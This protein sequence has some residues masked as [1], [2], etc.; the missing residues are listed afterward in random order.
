[1]Q[2]AYIF[3]FGPA[4]VTLTQKLDKIAGEPIAYHLF[5]RRDLE[6]KI[7]K[8]AIGQLR[9]ARLI[10]NVATQARRE[11]DQNEQKKLQ[12]ALEREKAAQEGALRLQ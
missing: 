3:K 12:K 9:L 7:D 2:G 10:F 5:K 6:Q 1:M 11:Y 8:L 4:T